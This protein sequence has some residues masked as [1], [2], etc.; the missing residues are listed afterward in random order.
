MLQEHVQGVIDA[1]MSVKAAAEQLNISEVYLRTV[2]SQH[3]G[4]AV[5]IHDKT[6]VTKEFVETYGGQRAAKLAAKVAAA[7]AAATPAEAVAA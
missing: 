1:T 7:E 3:A 6:F 4:S 2:I 5:R